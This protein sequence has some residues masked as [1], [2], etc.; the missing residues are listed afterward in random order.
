[1]QLME[2]KNDTTGL[3]KG[4]TEPSPMIEGV[5]F[6]RISNALSANVQALRENNESFTP[7][8]RTFLLFRVRDMIHALET[9]PSEEEEE[10]E[11]LEY[12][13]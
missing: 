3:G 6:C 12:S 7:H 4:K 5:E 10:Q 8:Q 11:M 1:M 9:G 2:R 13:E